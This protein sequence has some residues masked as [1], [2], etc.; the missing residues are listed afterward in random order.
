[1]NYEFLSRTFLFQGT[2]PEETKH[3]LSCLKATPQSYAKG[4]T[5]W[6]VGDQVKAMGLVLNGSG[7]IE[8]IDMTGNKS[9]LNRIAPGQV[10]GETYACIPGEKLLIGVTAAEDCQI[11]FLE[12]GKIFHTCPDTCP[13][14]E[15]LI[16]NMLMVM[17]KK[18]LEL[19]RRSLHTAPKSIR[20]RLLSYFSQEMVQQG[21]SRFMIPFNR[22]ELA[23]YLGVDRSVI[24]DIV[25]QKK[26][27][28]FFCQ[29]KMTEFFLENLCRVRHT[30]IL[31]TKVEDSDEFPRPVLES[32][33]G[34]CASV[35]LDS[36]ISLAFKTSRSSMVS[37]IEGGQ[38]FVN[39]KLITSNGYEPKDGDIISVRGKGRFIFD[40]VSHQTKKG[41]CSVRIMRYV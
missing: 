9:I 21:S 29:N 13:C 40:G 20:G 1:M 25:V 18:N 8:N 10:F 28:W 5:I 34:T 37:Y 31:I 4:S 23:D 30:N 26:A 19:S 6:Q 35:R 38:V 15:K 11:L 27:A 16:R 7:H 41:R 17:A 14:H 2:S 12:V 36:L 32:V 22:Q 33:S 24:G 39:G 3:M